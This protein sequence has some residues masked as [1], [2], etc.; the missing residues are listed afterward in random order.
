MDRANVKQQHPSFPQMTE[1][2]Q[3]SELLSLLV[4]KTLQVSKVKCS[5]S[6]EGRT[7]ALFVSTNLKM[8]ASLKRKHSN[9]FFRNQM[10][11]LKLMKLGT[12]KQTF[13]GCCE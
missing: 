1:I 7:L 11:T 5:R 6:E 9:G 4:S 13:M 8:F 3:H 12:S 2:Q 10:Q